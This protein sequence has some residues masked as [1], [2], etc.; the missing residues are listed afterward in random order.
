[1]RVCEGHVCWTT[2]EEIRKA[3]PL[4]QILSRGGR[5]PQAHERD[6]GI[7][8]RWSVVE[9]ICEISVKSECSAAAEK[10]HGG[11][12]GISAEGAWRMRSCASHTN[13][14]F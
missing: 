4:N 1:M 13:T 6:Q 2:L 14:H 8:A 11:A 9:D 3:P 12:Q 10:V 7:Y 5:S